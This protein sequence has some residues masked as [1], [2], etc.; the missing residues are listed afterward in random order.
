VAQEWVDFE[1]HIQVLIGIMGFL[2]AVW[3]V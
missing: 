1:S 3:F 2:D